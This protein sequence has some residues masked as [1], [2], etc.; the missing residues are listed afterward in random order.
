MLVVREADFT[1]MRSFPNHREQTGRKRKKILLLPIGISVL[2]DLTPKQPIDN[3]EIEKREHSA[4]Y[5]PG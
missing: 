5:P 1:A 3:A 2:R 4:E